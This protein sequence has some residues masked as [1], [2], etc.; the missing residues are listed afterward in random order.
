M[1]NK[2]DVWVDNVKVIACILVV[3]GHFFQSMVKSD[4]LPKT[5]LYG[6]FNDTIYYFHVPLFFICSG[7]LYQKYSKVVDFSSWK[8]SVL[9]KF[10]ALGIPYFVFSFATWFLKKMFSSSVNDELGGIVDTLIYHPASPYWYLYAL[11]FMFVITLTTKNVK[12]QIALLIIASILRVLFSIGAFSKF[13]QVFI[14]SKL[15][16]HWVWFII[17]MMLAYNYVKYVNA[18]IGVVMFVVFLIGSFIVRFWG[19][20]VVAN[21]GLMRFVLA[22][23]A[24]Y[25]VISIAHSLFENDV[26]NKCWQ[27]CARY[28]MPVFLMH[29]LFAAP[30]RSVLFKFGIHNSIIHVA[31]GLVIS[32]LGPVVAMIILEKLKPLDFIVYPTRYIK[33]GKGVKNGN[34]C[35][36][37]NNC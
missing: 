4:I 36:K 29:T 5:T 33:I 1:N 11:F 23:L 26:Q 28:T 9:K 30:L 20:G 3:L 7:F 2:R 21:E 17:G 27:F 35:T 14:I 15:C 18:L 24:C 13:S 34:N 10:L 19:A 12:N 22:V 32:F 6:W 31:A 16:E 25:S 37:E 8:K